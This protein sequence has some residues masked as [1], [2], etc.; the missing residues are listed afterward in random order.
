M[1]TAILAAL[2]EAAQG[3]V[4][5]DAQGVEQALAWLYRC[6]RAGLPVEQRLGL[7]ISKLGSVEFIDDAILQLSQSLSA[8]RY[9]LNLELV[10]NAVD[11]AAEDEDLLGIRSRGSYARLLN[12]MD[13]S[14]ESVW[15]IANY[16]LVI[17]SLAVIGAV[18]Y[19]RR[20]SEVPM[21]L[22]DEGDAAGGSHD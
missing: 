2:G 9:L 4:F 11:W 18:S 1:R 22:V 8:D 14:Q 7:E 6:H 10:Q 12:E 16:V 17:V 20:R 13:Q 3:F 21:E 19:T 5:R 15:E